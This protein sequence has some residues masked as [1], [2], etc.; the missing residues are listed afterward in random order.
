MHKKSKSKLRIEEPVL[1]HIKLKLIL[2]KRYI[3]KAI[4]YVVT[5]GLAIYMCGPS[6][7]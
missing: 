5:T 3:K 6:E 1:P 2:L 4:K 7:K